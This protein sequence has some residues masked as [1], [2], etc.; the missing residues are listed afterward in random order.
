MEISFK[1][2]QDLAY[3]GCSAGKFEPGVEYELDLDDMAVAQVVSAFAAGSLI[4][5]SVTPVEFAALIEP[6]EVSEAKLQE[7]MQDINSETGIS[8]WQEGHLQQFELDADYAEIE[9]GV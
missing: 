1:V 2:R 5:V 6:Q 7:A 4:E 8:R 9:I 3:W